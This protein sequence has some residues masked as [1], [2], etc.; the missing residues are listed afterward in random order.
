MEIKLTHGSSCA[1]VGHSTD[2]T[3]L[4]I[5]LFLFMIIFKRKLGGKLQVLVLTAQRCPRPL[6]YGGMETQGG[7]KCTVMWLFFLSQPKEANAKPDFSSYPLT[8][9]TDIV[10]VWKQSCVQQTS[11]IQR[12]DPSHEPSGSALCAFS[13]SPFSVVPTQ[14]T[15]VV[16]NSCFLKHRVL[17]IIPLVFPPSS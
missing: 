10:L 5:C 11:T 4:S 9:H 6:H 2:L 13:D 3:S 16:F 1:C 12:T 7:K 8:T 15:Q 14:V 17:C